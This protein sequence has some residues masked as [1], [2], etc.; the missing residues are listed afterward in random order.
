MRFLACS[1]GNNV[2]VPR[3]ILSASAFDVIVLIKRDGRVGWSLKSGEVALTELWLVLRTLAWQV[4]RSQAI[5]VMAAIAF[6]EQ[7]QKWEE[8]GIRGSI[9]SSKHTRTWSS[10]TF[11]TRLLRLLA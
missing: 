3:S 5:A 8:G 9:I 11:L 2:D 7:G 1:Y 10:E 6:H 4:W